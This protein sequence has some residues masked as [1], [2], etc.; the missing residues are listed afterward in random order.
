VCLRS[1][2][3]LLTER[4]VVALTQQCYAV[5]THVRDE[6]RMFTNQEIEGAVILQRPKIS[7]STQRTYR[8]YERKWEQYLEDRGIVGDILL[9]EIS[10]DAKVIVLST[11]LKELRDSGGVHGPAFAAV[12]NLFKKHGRSLD[13]FEAPVMS[14][15]RYWLAPTD[16]EV[17]ERRQANVKICATKQ[18]V[19]VQR[20]L[21]WDEG[22]T[23]ML[24]VMGVSYEYM[25]GPRVGNIA[26][27]S[28][29]KGEHMI[30]VQDVVFDVKT[31]SVSGAR[32]EAL[33]S[34]DLKTR[35]IAS[36]DCIKITFTHVGGKNFGGSKGVLVNV[37]DRGQ[38]FKDAEF[39][40][41]AVQF[42]MVADHGREDYFFSRNLGGYNKKFTA[43]AS[44]K[45]AKESAAVLGLPPKMFSTTSWRSGW[46]TAMSAA[47]I[48]DAELKLLNL[49]SSNA[50]F[51]Y[52]RP[53][54][55]R[56]NAGRVEGLSV[57]EVEAMVPAAVRRKHEEG[58]TDEERTRCDDLVRTLSSF[59]P[60]ISH[61]ADD[62]HG[63]LSSNK[64]IPR[65][66]AAAAADP[67]PGLILRLPINR[68]SGGEVRDD[69][70]PRA[71]PRK[72]YAVYG[73]DTGEG[74]LVTDEWAECNRHISSVV[75]KRRVVHKDAVFQSFPSQELA[76]AFA[77]YFRDLTVVDISGPTVSNKGGVR[78][79]YYG[80][81]RGEDSNGPITNYVVDTEGRM[82]A[83][84]IRSNGERV[85]GATWSSFESYH[86]A[87]AFAI[88][89]FPVEA[90]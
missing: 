63:A 4:E 44:A 39:I 64:E 20:E 48:S 25:F 66:G 82:R 22:A 2:C 62:G 34:F 11:W 71:L 46:A 70:G 81:F 3:S 1:L 90:T 7:D 38:S 6:L 40:D 72:W 43:S 75:D 35:A 83:L 42:A 8:S 18:F 76:H 30:R 32:V 73:G 74:G 52:N 27:D 37:V 10:L 14:H 60:G 78:K 79:R 57:N 19:D 29:N 89:G 9:D 5:A 68:K 21:H 85:P 87:R 69:E 61:S 28:A 12:R 16:R 49:W 54:G 88:T 51:L 45:A 13:V 50:S 80:I 55:K 23:G 86:D 53:N 41:M 24:H 47:G 33:F 84:T 56:P 77:A 36:S 15:V 31:E 58:R 65:V 67:Q 17:H 26:W 59:S